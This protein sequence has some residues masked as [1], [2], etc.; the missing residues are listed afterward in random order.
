MTPQDAYFILFWGGWFL[1][2][3]CAAGIME[4]YAK[5]GK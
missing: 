4:K 2:V 3:I 1:L 5:R